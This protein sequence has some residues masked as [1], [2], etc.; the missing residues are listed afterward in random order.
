MSTLSKQSI[1]EKEE[2]KRESRVANMSHKL[3]KLAEELVE[4]SYEADL[5]SRT[6]EDAVRRM[7]TQLRNCS[8]IL[9]S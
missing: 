3:Q 2:Y 9:D 4:W 8:D 5:Q 1:I 7:I 6:K